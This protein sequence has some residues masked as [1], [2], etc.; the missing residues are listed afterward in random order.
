[1][2]CYQCQNSGNFFQAKGFMRY[3]QNFMQARMSLCELPAK[4]YEGAAKLL[5]VFKTLFK[6]VKLYASVVFIFF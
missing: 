6:P 1:M 5:Q 4:C 3:A 2:A